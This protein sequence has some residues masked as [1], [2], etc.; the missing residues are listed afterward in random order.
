VPVKENGKT[1]RDIGGKRNGDHRNVCKRKVS[2]W[3]KGAIQNLNKTGGVLKYS[4]D[5]AG[6]NWGG[7]VLEK[8]RKQG[9]AERQKDIVSREKVGVRWE[10]RASR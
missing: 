2:R 5:A 4:D 6:Q 8:S 3:R 7:L 1:V 9:G 10:G